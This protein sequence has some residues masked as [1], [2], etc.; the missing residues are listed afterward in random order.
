MCR[1]GTSSGSGL[2][3]GVSPGGELWGF[4]P[5]E[6]DELLGGLPASGRILFNS[7]LANFE[8]GP[9]DVWVDYHNDNRAPLLFMSGE[10]DHIMPP[11]VQRSSVSV[12]LEQPGSVG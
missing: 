5:P 9:Q 11:A 3:D 1:P 8:P 7:I 4:V 6:F 10:H 2:I 12:T